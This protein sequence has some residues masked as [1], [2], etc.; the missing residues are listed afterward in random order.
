[1]KKTFFVTLA[2]AFAMLFA[3]PAQA[4][5]LKI[6]VKAGLNINSF[7]FKDFGDNFSSSNRAGFFVGPQLDITTPL[8]GLGVDIAALYE[9]KTVGFSQTMDM[10]VINPA[11]GQIL[12]DPSGAPILYP[13]TENSNK[14][15]QFIT[16]PINVKYSLGIG[17]KLSVYAATGPQVS[18]NI[19][20]KNFGNALGDMR[21]KDA[22]FSWNFGAGLTVLSHY[23]VGY[24][25]NLG[26]TNQLGSL[27]EVDGLGETID[28]I[29]SV[30]KSRTHQVSFTYIF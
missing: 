13:Y 27:K 11:T 17:S 24:N 26:I 25:F 4:Q 7:S 1:M 22:D 6:G 8:A 3:T 12:T 2:L 14:N 19:S 28:A 20:G 21:L 9:H 10:P 30:G 23:R 29:K 5:K 18:F 15:M 16:V